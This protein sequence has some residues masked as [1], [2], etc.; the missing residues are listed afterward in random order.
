M[1]VACCLSAGAVG[2]RYKA[3][4]DPWVIEQQAHRVLKAIAVH[5]IGIEIAGNHESRILQQ[6][7]MLTVIIVEPVQPCIGK[8]LSP[9]PD[10]I[11]VAQAVAIF[12]AIEHWRRRVRNQKVDHPERTAD[13]HI[14][15]RFR[16]QPQLLPNRIGVKR[17]A[18]IRVFRRQRAGQIGPAKLLEAAYRV[19]IYGITRQ[20]QHAV[21]P[22]M[23]AKTPGIAGAIAAAIA[24]QIK[25]AGD[26]GVHRAAEMM[27]VADGLL[28]ELADCQIITQKNRNRLAFVVVIKLIEQQHI[29]ALVLD[30]CSHLARRR[31]VIHQSRNQAAVAVGIQRGIE[32]GKTHGGGHVNGRL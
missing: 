22:R 18:G 23:P 15:V 29:R 1:A 21:L 31:I 30:D 12:R 13:R 32:G 27:R 24:I 3:R 2:S 28:T 11:V 10:F 7:A 17:G 19:C 4:I 26:T 8:I 5:R 6:A 14:P 20:H 25:A 16:R 9:E